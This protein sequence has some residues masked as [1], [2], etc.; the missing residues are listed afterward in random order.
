MN[1]SPVIVI[2]LDAADPQLIEQWTSAGYLPTLARLRQQGLYRRL[3]SNVDYCGKATPASS[4]DKVWV[5]FSSGCLPNKTGFWDTAHFQKESYRI[6]FD[7]HTSGYDYREYPPFYA[8]G[9]DYRVATFDL[10]VSALSDQIQGLQILGWGGHFP[11]TPNH[12]SPPE[13]LPELIQR[14]GENPVIYKDH[15]YWWDPSYADWL[16]EALIQSAATRAQI[17]CDLLCRDRWDLFLTV[18][19]EAHSAGHDLWH[20]S[21]P[22]HPLYATWG[23][24]RGEDLMLKA[25]QAIDRGIEQVVNAA[26]ENATIICSSVHGMGVNYTDLLSMAILPELIYRFNFPGKV[27]IAPGNSHTPPPALITKPLR[28]TWAGEVWSRK[29]EANPL[30]R[31]L[32]PWTPSRFLHAYPQPDVISPYQLHAQGEKLSWI[33]ALWFSPLWPQMQAFALPAFSDGL[34]RINLQG[35]ESQGIVAPQEYDALCQRLTDMLLQLRDGRT[36]QPIVKEVVRTRP[37]PTADGSQYPD[38]DLT[39]L[40]HEYPSD[41]VDSPQLGRV[42][43]L[44]Y[45][46][47]GGHRGQ[48][49]VIAKGQGIAAG[50]ELTEPAQVVDLAPTILELLQAPRPDHLDGQSLLQSMYQ[51]V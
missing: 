24:Q 40:W 25:F 39:V 8:L 30:R 18:F 48:G 49:F 13:L 38:A 12:S 37:T 20:L 10:P 42:G 1:P 27:A 9:D 29:Y 36:G 23:Q 15:G 47:P 31:W 28:R 2:C 16:T 35:R 11:F 43:P 34:I 7:H 6:R 32:R 46:R 41:V 3:E 14:Y 33:P 17:C 22:D 5:M 21:Q 44:P 26:P 51:V 19:G 50:T 4:T 45:S